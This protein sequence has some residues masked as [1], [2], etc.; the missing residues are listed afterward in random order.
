MGIFC[1]VFCYLC[2][3]FVKLFKQ[4]KTQKILL[5]THALQCHHSYIQV[6]F[7]SKV[8]ESPT[9]HTLVNYTL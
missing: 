7:I 3:S 9:L 8:Y 6:P 1:S 2:Y 4:K 5:N